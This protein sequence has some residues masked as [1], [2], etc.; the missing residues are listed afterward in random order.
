MVK[1]DFD[2]VLIV[3]QFSDI[4]SRSQVDVTTTIQGKW[5]TSITGAPSLLPIWMVSVH[6]VCIVH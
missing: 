3:P 1:L 6:L 4:T 2:D 5:G